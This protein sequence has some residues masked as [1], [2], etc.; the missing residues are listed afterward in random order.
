MINNIVSTVKKSSIYLLM[1]MTNILLITTIVYFIKITVTPF[2]LP[3]IFILSIIEYCILYK[4]EKWKEKLIPIVI[5]TVIFITSII[6]SSNVY[7]TTADGNTYHKLAIG[8]LKNGWNPSYESSRDF[9]KEKGNVFDVS[10]DNINALWVD[11]YAKATEIFAS[12]IYSFTNN[13]ESGKAYTLIFMYIT[14]AIIGSYLYENKKMHWL[15]AFAISFIIAFNGIT[16]VQI[17]NYY[18]DA[19]LMLSL[20][21]I[22][23]SCFIISTNE[24]KNTRKETFII[25]A[26]SI[27]WCINAKF[28]GLAFSGLFCLAFYIYWL[29]ISYKK[30]KEVLKKDLITYTIFYTIV[31]IISIRNN[32]I[33]FIHKELFRPW[34]STVSI[35]WK[36]TCR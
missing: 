16:I 17:C 30:G 31:V 20:A 10:D 22:L 8:A 23:Y 14:F 29:Y 4:K 5:G 33:F 27:I 12:V 9:T 3:I 7:D 21:L 24:D 6:I 25:L 26:S 18:V 1:V 13:I 32:W 15:I 11:H 35:I 2:H 19:V 28:T 34:T 36:R